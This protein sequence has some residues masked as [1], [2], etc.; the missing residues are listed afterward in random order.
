MSNP[1]TLDNLA[2][3][4]V[5]NKNLATQNDVS[6]IIPSQTSN[7]NKFL[8]TDSQLLFYPHNNTRYKFSKCRI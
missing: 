3:A 6:T 8:T 1:I 4:I 5:N 2:T 7:A